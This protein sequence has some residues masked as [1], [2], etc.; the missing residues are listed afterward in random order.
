M[1]PRFSMALAAGLRIIAAAS[2]RTPAAA[3]PATLFNFDGIWQ[4]SV[5]L[6]AFKRSSTKN[7]EIQEY[8]RR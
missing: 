5:N 8:C 7:R 6:K 4:F 1:K 3:V 2:P